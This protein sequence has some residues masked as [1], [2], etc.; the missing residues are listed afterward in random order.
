MTRHKHTENLTF[1]PETL[2]GWDKLND[3]EKT[4]VKTETTELSEAVI[5]MGR[6]RLG[7]GQHL[8]M[9]REILEPKR[10]FVAYI[11]NFRFSRATAYRYIDQYKGVSEKLPTPIMDIAI[12][13]GYQN[14]SSKAVAE[15]LPPKTENEDKIIEYLD[16]VEK[17]K[18]PVPQE[19][20]YNPDSL[21]K[22]CFNFVHL[23]FQRLP[24]SGRTR[25]AWMRMFTGMLLT[26]L[27][28]SSD[29]SI[30]PVAIPTEYRTQ[31]GRP[32]LKKAA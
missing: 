12:A 31:P 1:D 22:E 30:S 19:K 16:A 10:M 14:I 26:E 5:Q 32:K 4:V 7:I 21:M 9:L 2:Q 8:L 18:K 20:S 15:I 23:R 27:G 25:S 29:Q 28:V 17:M 11:K 3:D 24:K 13:K 6:S